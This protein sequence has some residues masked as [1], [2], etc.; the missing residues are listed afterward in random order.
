MSTHAALENT[1]RLW[2][3]SISLTLLL[4]CL[5][6]VHPEVFG[7]SPAK[8]ETIRVINETMGPS[9][10]LKCL[11]G[12]LYIIQHN[13]SGKTISQDRVSPEL[14][15]LTIF[16]DEENNLLCIPC[17]NGQQQC[18]TRTLS[19]NQRKRTLNSLNIPVKDTREFYLLMR[20]FEHLIRLTSEND[21]KAEVYFD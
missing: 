4:T 13:E 18:V 3:S 11:S 17:M 10:S 9:T 2:G 16:H 21:Y 12:E 15:D 8:E 5:T 20:A 1:L 6:L 7:Q 19:S 14:L